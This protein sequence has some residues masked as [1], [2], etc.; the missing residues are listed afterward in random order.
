MLFS[1]QD[2]KLFKLFFE[3]LHEANCSKDILCC[4]YCSIGY[5]IMKKNIYQ[6][7]DL[8]Y[9]YLF[10]LFNHMSINLNPL[11]LAH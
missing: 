3:P 6:E 10:K 1:F 9:S 5:T 8:D 2:D 4:Q 7:L 11:R